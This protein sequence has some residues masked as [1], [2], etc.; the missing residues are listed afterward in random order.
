MSDLKEA[1]AAVERLTSAWG[2]VLKVWEQLPPDEH[3][4]LTKG[5]PF[6]ACFFELYHELLNWQSIVGEAAG[7]FD[8]EE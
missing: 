1:Y 6:N 2:D 4:R 7:V 5:Y 3:D 8:G